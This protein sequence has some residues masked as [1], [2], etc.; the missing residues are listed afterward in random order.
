MGIP[1]YTRIVLIPSNED[2]SREFGIARSAIVTL[3]V[4]FV[5]LAVLMGLLMVSFAG[6]FDERMQIA[7]LEQELAQAQSALGAA[8]E[9]ASELEGMK[10]AQEK[11]LFMLG[12]EEVVAAD[13]LRL[14][15][16]DE[17][18][19]A[20]IAMQRAA[21]LVLNPG[22]N[23][24]PASGVVSQEFIKGNLAR[25]IKPHQGI[26][27]AGRL[28]TPILAS[29]SGTVFRTGKDE[30]LGNFV[31]IQ[32]GL[33]YL[34]VYGHCSRV[35]VQKGDPVEGGQVIA[36]MGT[37]GQSTA[38]HLHFEVWRQGE[39]IDPRSLLEGDPARN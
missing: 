38:V 28:D 3:V 34:T 25:G 14:W 26:D 31:E 23:R 1:S 4:L 32:H 37:S 22:P 29:V 7:K 15:S 9:L 27:V 24:W 10:Q 21:S 17:P 6:K 18:A 30:Y 33:G 11:L 20:A 39:A 12:V 16:D 36:Y 5:T 35:A 13:S 8:N 19:S 2:P